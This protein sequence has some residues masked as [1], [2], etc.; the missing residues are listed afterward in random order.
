MKRLFIAFLVFSFPAFVHAHPG[1]TDLYGGHRCLRGCE[2]W[3]L[4][5]GEYHLHD[6]DGRPIRL[7]RSKGRKSHRDSLRDQQETTTASEA[8]EPASQATSSPGAVK[9][10]LPPLKP[11]E[12]NL[13]VLHPLLSALALLLLL[14]LVLRRS[15]KAGLKKE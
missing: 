1:K 14:F 7:A 11:Q 9:P 3:G 2:D 6:K 8:H 15:R 10:E 12:E 13:F 4:F 5:T